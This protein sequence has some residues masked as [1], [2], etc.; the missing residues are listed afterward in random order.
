MFLFDGFPL[1][2]SEVRIPEMPARFGSVK[3][4]IGQAQDFRVAQLQEA[5]HGRIH[6][7]VFRC[8]GPSCIRSP[9]R[10]QRVALRRSSLCLQLRFGPLSLGNFLPEPPVGGLQ[11]LTLGLFL[12]KELGHV[13]RVFQRLPIREDFFTGRLFMF[14]LGSG[15]GVTAS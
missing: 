3:T 12:P 10:S 4:L 1:Q 14:G 15:L 7:G 6:V 2:Y 11:F 13:F 5:G 8:G 9:E